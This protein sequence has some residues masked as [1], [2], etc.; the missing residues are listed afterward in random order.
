[1]G[2]FR[3]AKEE[4]YYKINR[5]VE[6]GEERRPP[7]KSGARHLSSIPSPSTLQIYPPPSYPPMTLP[8]P[9]FMFKFFKEI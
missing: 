6:E 3:L 4:G 2:G 9:L 7:T 1:M 5:K 8:Q